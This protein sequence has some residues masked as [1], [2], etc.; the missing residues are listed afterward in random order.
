[1]YK[2]SHPHRQAVSL[3]RTLASVAVAFGLAAGGAAAK[4]YKLPHSADAQHPNH[5]ALVEMAKRI[6]ERTKNEVTF[7]IFP[8]N[9]L[10]SPPEQT[11]QL[12]RGVVEFSVLS[13]AQLDKYDRAFGVV[14]IPYQFDGY[15]HAYRTLDETANKWLAAHA[16]KAGFEYIANF[17]WGFRALTN[18]RR[19][20]NG[21]E[22]VKGM[23][24]RVPPEIQIKAAM[25]ALGAVTATIAFPEVYTALATNTVDGQDNPVATVYSSKFYEVQKYL[26][27]TK[28][29]YTP[30]FLLANSS[31]WKSLTP[32]QRQIITEE[33]VRAG[34]EARKQVQEKEKEYIA[35]MEK[36]GIKTTYPDVAKFR[37]MMGPANAAIKEYVGGAAWDEWAKL[38]EASRKK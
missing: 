19:P 20:V 9:E 7:K 5:L 32:E 2:R 28:H 36:A 30:M 35:Q 18:S 37:A 22:D 31:V 14:F 29:V 17:E 3:V 15:E 23:K 21:P 1:M 38:I 12:R 25:E 27:M 34:N 13:P 11:E 33:G 10:G 4:E 26:A 24:L 8:N 16:E 6:A